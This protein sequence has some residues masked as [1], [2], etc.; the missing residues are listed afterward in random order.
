MNYSVLMSVYFKER[1]KWL[2]I[3]LDSMM[4]QT[5]L[6]DDFVLVE[7]GPL[8]A[9]LDAVVNEYCQKYSNIFHVVKLEKNVGLGPALEHGIKCCKNELI[10]RMDSDDYSVP[11]RCEKL[12][13][14]YREHQELDVIGSFEAEF[15]D[16]SMKVLSCHKV[17]E[18]NEEIHTFMKKRCALLHPT[19]MYKK[20]AVIR[21]GNYRSVRLYEDY[22]LFMR[23]VVEH[24]CKAYNIQENLYYI[25][26]NS[27]FFIRRGGWNYLQTVVGFKYKQLRKGNMSILDFVVSAGGQAVVCLMPNRMRRWFYKRFLR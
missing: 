10:I 2:R 1:P 26:V 15:E 23:M 9:E 4:N 13:A 7:D 22:D 20:S 8:T 27:D 16:E 25:R 3:S 12:L 11:E 5:V 18:S 24:N 19:V 6:T 21:A 14:V 17:P